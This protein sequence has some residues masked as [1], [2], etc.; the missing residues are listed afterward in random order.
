VTTN[1][2]LKPLATALE[3]LDGKPDLLSKAMH[4]VI[5]EAVIKIRNF[6]P[7]DPVGHMPPDLR[8]AVT[9][10]LAVLDQHTKDTWT[11][12]PMPTAATGADQ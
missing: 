11:M 5:D 3:S 7:A 10:A 1:P 4:L 8:A 12:P 9:L 2:I 6:Y